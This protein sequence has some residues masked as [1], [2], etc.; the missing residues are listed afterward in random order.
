MLSE[1]HHVAGPLHQAGFV[2]FRRDIREVIAN[3]E[4]I[5]RPHVS[6]L[7]VDVDRLHLLQAAAFD[8]FNHSLSTITA[9][10]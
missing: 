3:K 2:S 1:L 10:A 6:P 9:S 8:S 4:Q 7:M 5:P